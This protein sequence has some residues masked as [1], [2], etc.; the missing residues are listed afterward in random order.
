MKFV[1][2][3]FLFALAAIS[4]PV[5]IHLFNFRKFKKIIFTNVKF[6]KEV[7]EQTQSKSKLKHLLVLIT[8]ILAISFLVFAFAQPYFPKNDKAISS[9]DKVVSVFIDNSFS[10]NAENGKGI[11]FEQAKNTALQIANSYSTADRFQLLT[12]NFEGRHQRLVTKTEFSSM[13]N[14]LEPTP[15]SK[16]LSEIVSRQRDALSTSDSK[17][18]RAFVIS[19][20]QKS[21]ANIEK[22]NSDSLIDFS[23]VQLKANAANNIYIDSAW[24]KTP[25]RLLNQSEKLT[26]KIKNNGEQNVE[27][28]P[29]K[30]SVNGTQKSFTSFSIN[31]NSYCDSSVYFTN[32]EKGLQKADIYIKDSPIN[33]DDHFYLSYKIADKI[34]VLSINSNTSADKIDYFGSIFGNDSSFNYSAVSLSNI[35]FSGLKKFNLIILFELDAIPSGL[36]QELKKFTQNGGSIFIIPSETIDNISYN[37]FTTALQSSNYRDFVS[38][39]TRVSFINLDHPMYRDVFE[40][41]PKNL[42]YPVASSFY[43]LSK[44]ITSNEEVLLKLQ[45]NGTFLNKFNYG[46][47]K[48]YQCAVPLNTDKNNFAKHAL[49]VTS[50]LRMAEF[51]GVS[52]KLYYTIGFDEPIV[53]PNFTGQNET[54]FHLMNDEKSIDIIPEHYTINGKTEVFTRNQ[55]EKAG[56]YNLF[57]GT[58]LVTSVSFNYDK[59]ESELSYFSKIDLEEKISQNLLSGFSILDNN[60]SDINTKINELDAGKKYWKWCIL[61][62]LIFLGLEVLLLRF[63]KN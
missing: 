49:F 34:N 31:N 53:I 36:Q 7:K 16:N 56:N 44:N 61:L 11:L 8:R 5:I 28:L 30:L 54:V 40:K 14:D 17:S 1:Y 57:Y 21:M 20:F 27:D 29:L 45:N 50:V 48:I 26:I 62:A 58:E 24:F 12:N 4:I 23:L 51:S 9:G 3:E 19:D 60:I 47:G 52:E 32:T 43:N 15:S 39:E 35:D 25:F 2:P 6:L 18:K 37:D 42:D 59:K 13:V 38:Q 46:N 22:L 63:L 10:M 41:I 55:I 33:F